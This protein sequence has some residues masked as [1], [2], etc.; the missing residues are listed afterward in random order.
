MYTRDDIYLSDETDLDDDY[1]ELNV[2]QMIDYLR[3]IESAVV[4]DPCLEDMA[5]HLA[6]LRSE[7]EYRRQLAIEVAAEIDAQ[8]SVV[9]H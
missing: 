7:L 8:H 9:E 4:D 5:S 1:C 6:V 2:V 3:A